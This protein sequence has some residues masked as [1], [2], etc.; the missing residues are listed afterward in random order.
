MTG[1]TPASATRFVAYY[2]VSTDKQGRS[3]LG[4]EAQREAVAR[5]VASVNGA[6]VAEMQEVESGKRADRPQLQA[7]ISA[8]RVKRAVLVIAKLDRLTR[9]VAFLANLM[10]GGVEFV[11]CDNPHATRFTIHIL[12][13]V[14]EHEREM[15]SARTKAALAAAKARGVRLGNP[16]LRAGD[17]ETMRLARSA[18]SALANDYA[19]DVQPFIQ[20]AR[21]AGAD[22]YGQIAKA[23]MARGVRTPRGTVRFCSAPANRT[24]LDLGLLARIDPPHGSV[25]GRR[26]ER[27]RPDGFGRRTLLTEWAAEEGPTGRADQARPHR[28]SRPEMRTGAADMGPRNRYS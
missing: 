15:I 9:N 13:A 4:L 27:R 6:I 14:A 17:V 26:R 28:P 19:A 21:R 24:G 1:L 8:A 2:R 3:G 11:A 23:L 7:A 12:A 5:H 16:S 20:A 22:T 18:K 25:R 10:E